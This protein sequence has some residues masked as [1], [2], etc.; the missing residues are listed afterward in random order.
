MRQEGFYTPFGVRC[1]G[2][3]WLLDF[4]DKYY[5]TFLYA[6]RREVLRNAPRATERVAADGMRFYTPFGVRCF[7]T[8]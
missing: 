8:S 7:G 6:L 4:T 3:L 1:F 2:T 5:R